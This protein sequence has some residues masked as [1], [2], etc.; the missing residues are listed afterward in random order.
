MPTALTAAL[1]T[2]AASLRQNYA[3]TK[4]VQSLLTLPNDAFFPIVVF[5]GTAEMKSNLG[6]NVFKLGGLIP[7]LVAS[8]PS[9]LD[10]RKMA[11]VVGRIEMKRLRRS[12]E[13]DEYHLNSV[14]QRVAE[15]A[16]A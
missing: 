7:H 11:Y 6:P 14:R 9:V 8:R 15:N 4:A 13:T 2:S 1:A 12:L 10:E 3:H 16:R 5:T